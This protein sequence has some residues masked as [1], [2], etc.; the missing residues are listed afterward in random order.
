MAPTASPELDENGY[1]TY[2][3]YKSRTGQEQMDYM[4]STFKKPDGKVDVAAFN[5]WYHAAK[6]AYDEAHPKE[7][8]GPDGIIDLH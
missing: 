5:R 4:Y 1:W 3:Y 7:T 6:K 8:I 2:E